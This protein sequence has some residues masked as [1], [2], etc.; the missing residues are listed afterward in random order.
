MLSCLKSNIVVSSVAVLN[1][2]PF[3]LFHIYS[4]FG[5]PQSIYRQKQDFLAFQ[6]DLISGKTLPFFSA[7]LSYQQILPK[8]KSVFSVWLMLFITV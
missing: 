2:I 6:Y 8:L 1:D 7:Y 4:V 3:F 5:L